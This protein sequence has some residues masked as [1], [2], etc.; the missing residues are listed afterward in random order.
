MPTKLATA[1]WYWPVLSEAIE[2]QLALIAFDLTQVVVE[3]KSCL[4]A[5]GIVISLGSVML[6]YTVSCVDCASACGKMC[7]VIAFVGTTIS[8]LLSASTAQYINSRIIHEQRVVYK[9]QAEREV[10]LMP[11]ICCN[12]GF[13]GLDELNESK[14]K[15]NEIIGCRWIFITTVISVRAHLFD[16]WTTRC[17][18]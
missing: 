7:S 5:V 17:E 1:A 2:Y 14:I 15:K 16:D 8:V 4:E 11:F 13:G 9:C 18:D 12:L 3:L 10:S 6:L